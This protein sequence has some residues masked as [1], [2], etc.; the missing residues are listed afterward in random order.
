MLGPEVFQ[1]WEIFGL[2]LHGVERSLIQKSKILKFSKIQNFCFW[3][4]GLKRRASSWLGK[5]FT[6]VKTFGAG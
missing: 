1:M 3:Y 4:W 5:Y 2:F 6:G